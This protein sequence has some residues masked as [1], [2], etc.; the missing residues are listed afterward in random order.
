M[1]AHLMLP[2]QAR[3]DE[4]LV[5]LGLAAA[6]GGPPRMLAL[7]HLEGGRVGQREITRM[8]RHRQVGQTE[9]VNVGPGGRVT[10]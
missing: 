4:R 9:V 7:V 8:A 5:A 10:R 6:V 3:A 1:A 2:K